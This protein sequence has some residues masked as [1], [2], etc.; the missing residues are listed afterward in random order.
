ME[1]MRRSGPLTVSIM[2]LI[3]FTLVIL[4]LAWIMVL[5]GEQL[6]AEAAEQQTRSL[7]YYQYGRGDILD[8]YGRPLTGTLENC[9]VIF[10]A[11]VEEQDTAIATI[12]Q[13][14]GVDESVVAERMDT[15][16]TDY[17]PYVLYAGLDGEQAEQIL[18]ADLPG[19]TSLQL[20]ARYSRAYPAVHLIGFCQQQDGIWQGKSGLEL[21]YDSFL[22]GR[23]DDRLVAY[24]DA[25]G[26]LSQNQLYLVEEEPSYHTLQL[27]LD[28][29]YQQIVENAFASLGYSGA[30]VILDPENGDILAAASV[31]GYDPYFW[32]PVGTDAYVNKVFAL[33]HPAST[34]KTVLTAA[35]LQEGIPLPEVG[36]SAIE[37]ASALREEDASDTQGLQESNG[38][39]TSLLDGVEEGFL[40]TGTYQ[41]ASERQVS[42]TSAPEG[43]GVL[44]L[45]QALAK[46]CNCYFVALGQT[47]GGSWIRSYSQRLGLV[48]QQVI[49]YTLNDYAASAYLDFSD[50][51]PAD[52]ANVSLGE[53]GV[54]VSPL[55]EAVLFSTFVNGGYRVTPRLVEQI[56]TQSGEV[57]QS[58]PSSPRTRVLSEEVADQIQ[59]MLVQCVEDGTAAAISGSL[60]TAG[61]KTGTSESGGVWFSGFAPAD[62]PRWVIVVH[63]DGGSAGGVEAAA[64]FRNIIEGIC[65]LAAE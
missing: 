20:A 45:E 24:V 60:I 32:Q 30:G 44:D 37:D 21:Q 25:D 16:N 11:M 59:A 54:M 1:T 4:R 62:Q 36:D 26:R 46:S 27:T 56:T 34:F 61:G 6:S 5:Q 53:R 29:D 12:G 47:L 7:E 3:L 10:P 50:Q 28:M 52:I 58:F 19:V 13:V 51:V 43:H 49:G 40:C 42:C 38:D 57:V 14:L 31:S 15:G 35:A 8:R 2:I 64:V 9:L 17:S 22:S 23:V 65:Q 18:A 39:A 41:F 48:G 63:V 33:Y 55:Q